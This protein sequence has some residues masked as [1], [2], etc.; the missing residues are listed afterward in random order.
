LLR[1]WARGGRNSRFVPLRL[2]CKG[3]HIEPTS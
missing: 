3:V 2:L 1:I